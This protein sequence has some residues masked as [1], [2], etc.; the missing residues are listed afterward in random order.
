MRKKLTFYIATDVKGF[1]KNDVTIDR[2]DL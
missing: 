1:F 2:T